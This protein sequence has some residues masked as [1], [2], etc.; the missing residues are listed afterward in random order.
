MILR[1]TIS[2]LTPPASDY[3][4]TITVVAAGTF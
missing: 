2:T 4:D 1:S 3:T